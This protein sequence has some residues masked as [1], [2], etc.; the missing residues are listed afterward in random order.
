VPITVT[1]LVDRWHGDPITKMR[2]AARTKLPP[3]RFTGDPVRRN[4]PSALVDDLVELAVLY[5]TR[6]GR[7]NMPDI[8]RVG[9]GIRR[10][11]GVRP[12]R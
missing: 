5:R 11:G 4:N 12:P 3:R 1:D 6:D 9:F 10:K 2:R 8:F 7:L